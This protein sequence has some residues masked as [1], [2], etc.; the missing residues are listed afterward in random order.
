VPSASTGQAG[1]VQLSDSTTSN[2]TT[3]APTANAVK[4]VNDRV[5]SLEVLY[6]MGGI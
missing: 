3:Q 5:N 1:I 6:W 2:S 4:T